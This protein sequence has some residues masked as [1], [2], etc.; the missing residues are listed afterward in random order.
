MSLKFFLFSSLRPVY[1]RGE[2]QSRYKAPIALFMQKKNEKIG[3]KSKSM[4]HS[5]R[6]LSNEDVFENIT[7]RTNRHVVHPKSKTLCNLMLP[8]KSIQVHS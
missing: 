1:R 4:A 7:L 2:N 6:I 5:Q 3:G 8:R